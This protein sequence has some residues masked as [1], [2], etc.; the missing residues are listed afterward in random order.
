MAPWADYLYG[1]DP[2]WW[3]HHL[4]KIR[5]LG[6][7]SRL[8]APDVPKH[9]SHNAEFAKEHGL[10]PW[11]ARQI[12]KGLGEDVI[13]TAGNS[14]Y[15]AMNLAYLEG[16]QRILFLGLDMK[17]AP[18][19]KRHFFGNHPGKMNKASNYKAFMA[20]FRSVTPEHYGLEIINC[21]RDTALEH[22]RRAPIDDCL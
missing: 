8:C 1:C 15:Q 22:F 6:V 4:P 2:E 7:T 16:A 12:S 19:G 11:P 20:S 14:G 9:K 10:E 21:S 5:A 3:T 17:V 13:H 18:N